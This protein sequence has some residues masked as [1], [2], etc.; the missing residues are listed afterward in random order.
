MLHTPTHQ[1][2]RHPSSP[3]A[4]LRVSAGSS[5]G[6]RMHTHAEYSVGIVDAGEAI[7][8]HPSGPEKV[9]RGS[10]VLIEPGVIHACNPSQQQVWSYRMLFLDANWLHDQIKKWHHLSEPVTALH[11]AARHINDPATSALVDQLCQASATALDVRQQTQLLTPWL[12]ALAQQGKPSDQPSYSVALEPALRHVYSGANHGMTV[13]ELAQ[14]CAMSPSQFIR[15]FKGVMGLPP[16]QYLQNLRINGARSLI[17]SGVSL[18]DT[19]YAMGF[20]DQAHLQRAFKVRHA[21]TP[22]N[23]APPRTATGRR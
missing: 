14:Q 1:L 12:A 18:A 11:F 7:F 16:G 4:E 17:A 21:M 10:V 5:N 9:C 22:G 3:W 23:Y 13:R 19:A 2:H 8:H 20:A 15:R 6:Y